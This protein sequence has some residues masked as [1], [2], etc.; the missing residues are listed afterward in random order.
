V[1]VA[2]EAAAVITGRGAIRLGC[3]QLAGKKA[4]PIE[5]FLHGRP[6][7][8]TAHLSLIPDA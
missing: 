1:F 4:T 3:I 6:D 7:F 5:E 8:A 2:D